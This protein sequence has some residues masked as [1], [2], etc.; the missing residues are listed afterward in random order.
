MCSQHHKHPCLVMEKHHHSGPWVLAWGLLSYHDTCGGVTIPGGGPKL[1]LLSSPQLSQPGRQAQGERRDVWGWFLPRQEEVEGGTSQC[2]Q[3]LLACSQTSSWGW[4]VGIHFPAA[5]WRTDSL[6]LPMGPG[7]AVP[8]SSCPPMPSLAVSTLALGPAL[9]QPLCRQL[10]Q[11]EGTIP[12]SCGGPRPWL[13]PQVPRVSS[14]VWAWKQTRLASQP[15]VSFW[16]QSLGKFVSA[17][18][19]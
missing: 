8:A 15:T 5:S 3:S 7:Q 13:G 1:S 4:S 16:S 12:Q 10:C 11:Q 17:V 18:C 9:A 19:I 6:S 2:H 14:G